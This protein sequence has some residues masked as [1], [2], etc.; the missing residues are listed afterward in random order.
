MT[1][2]TPY[3]LIWFSVAA[4]ETK[5]ILN[6]TRALDKDGNENYRI[7]FPSPLLCLVDDV[8][9]LCPRLR[10]LRHHVWAI[11]NC[12]CFFVFL[13]T[14]NLVAAMFFYSLYR[15]H[16]TLICTHIFL[17]KYML[18]HYIQFILGDAIKHAESPNFFSLTW[19]STCSMH[20]K[21]LQFVQQ[22]VQGKQN[23]VQ[24]PRSVAYSCSS[25]LRTLHNLL[26]IISKEV[27][28][29]SLLIRNGKVWSATIHLWHAY[30]SFNFI[31]GKM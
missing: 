17:T 24:R 28:S 6:A 1:N 21:K 29:R 15:S 25:R 5:D 14:F 13:A 23:I 10:I 31:S 26:Y 16:W 12:C 2:N 19:S 27:L 9:Q 4:K 8:T 7:E 11:R 30:S 3:G 20:I 18:S 22:T